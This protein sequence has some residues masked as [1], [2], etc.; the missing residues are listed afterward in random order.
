ML[1]ALEDFRETVE[2]AAARLLLITEEESERRVA[3][4]KWSPK[5]IVGHLIDSAAN[6]HQRFVRAQFTDDLDFP[7]YEQEAWVAAQCYQ[8]ESWPQLIALWRAY[9]QHLR[10]VVSCIP[11]EKLKQLRARHSL[12]RIAWRL[13]G[14][15]QP[16]TLE[17][18]I[19]DY[20]AHLKHHLSQIF[21]EE[22]RI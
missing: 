6:N 18:L 9:N 12:D 2:G 14:A 19:R 13:V 5:E 7:G 1:D 4:G 16:A 15:D 3:D 17:Y 8:R 10:H 20:I 11:E 21:I 22:S